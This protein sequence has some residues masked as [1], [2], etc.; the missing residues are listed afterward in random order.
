MN[1]ACAQNDE[2]LIK[3]MFI[4]IDWI[5]VD[6]LPLICIVTMICT[7]YYLLNIFI[8]FNAYNF[9][10]IIILLMLAIKTYS[11]IENIQLMERIKRI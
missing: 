6:C 8:T 10:I 4:F 11:R 1:V 7:I 2:V 9:F 5:D 3:E